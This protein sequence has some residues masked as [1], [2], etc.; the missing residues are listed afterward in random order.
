MTSAGAMQVVAIL[1]A[2]CALAFVAFSTAY[3]VRN[4]RMAMA[5]RERE[6][7]AAVLGAGANQAQARMVGIGVGHVVRPAVHAR[8][9]RKRSE[10]EGP[11]G[12]N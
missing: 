1:L 9:P 5:A 6:R 12:S 10:K 4:R 8:E 7:Q 2:L 11:H 3:Y